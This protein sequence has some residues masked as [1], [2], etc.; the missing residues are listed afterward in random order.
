M[1][2]KEDCIEKICNLPLDYKVADKS[3]LTLLQE[4]KFAY[5]YNE[6]AIQDIKEYL[7]RHK[8]L[9]DN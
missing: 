4:S 3:S 9:I 5:F 7:S 8:N 6:I 2:T 1:T